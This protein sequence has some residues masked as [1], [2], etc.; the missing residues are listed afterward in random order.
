MGMGLISDTQTADV[1]KKIE[2]TVQSSPNCRRRSDCSFD[3]IKQYCT[4]NT[5]GAPLSGDDPR[6]PVLEVVLRFTTAV[7]V[8]QELK[9]F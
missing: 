3:S 6:C 4:K 5:A 1:L 8:L 9:N 7:S 2:V